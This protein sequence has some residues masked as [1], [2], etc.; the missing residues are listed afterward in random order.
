MQWVKRTHYWLNLHKHPKK[1][2]NNSTSKV[3]Y[4]KDDTLIAV[5]SLE[6]KSNFFLFFWKVHS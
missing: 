4:A 5:N 3:D 1:R 6:N 2:R